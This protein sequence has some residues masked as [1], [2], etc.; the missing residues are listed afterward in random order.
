MNSNTAALHD[1][2]SGRVVSRFLPHHPSA[3]APGD[4][5]NAPTATGLRRRRDAA[6]LPSSHCLQR[7][8]MRARTCPV[9]KSTLVTT[10]SLPSPQ[11]QHHTSTSF[12]KPET[13][14]RQKPKSH[15]L[16][17]RE[18]GKRRRSGWVNGPARDTARG[19]QPFGA[20]GPSTA[21][22]DGLFGVQGGW[23]RG[24]T[25][26]ALLAGNRLLASRPFP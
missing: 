15:T 14:E 4:E 12:N 19:Q 2:D 23:R 3:T 17:E 1:P 25:A 9:L 16:A 13:N 6:R 11:N 5:R 10:C 7:T 21:T 8:A 22:G 24:G 18:R 26:R 20:R